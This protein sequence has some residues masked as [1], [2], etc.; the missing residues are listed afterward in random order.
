MAQKAKDIKH[1]SSQLNHSA[2]DAV[3]KIVVPNPDEL[4]QRRNTQDSFEIADTRLIN[5]NDSATVT[6]SLDNR[7]KLNPSQITNGETVTQKLPG[8]IENSLDVDHQWNYNKYD[9]RRPVTVQNG[10][11]HIKIEKKK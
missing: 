3:Q 9:V 4:Q 7:Q 2:A 5:S 10:I 8:M 1:S 6:A 11:G